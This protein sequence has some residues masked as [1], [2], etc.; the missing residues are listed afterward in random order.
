MKYVIGCDAHKRYSQFSVIDAMGRVYLQKRVNHDR[1]ATH[2]FLSRFP[3]G[4]PV[5]FESIGNWYW[6]VDEIAQDAN[7][8]WRMR[9]KPN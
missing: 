9:S 4:T 8:R 7:Q 5:A 3:K 6:L 2:E 1:G